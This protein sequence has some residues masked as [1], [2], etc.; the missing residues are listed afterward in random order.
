MAEKKI[1]SVHVGGRR[2]RIRSD[3]NEGWLQGVA[4]YVDESMGRIQSRTETVDSLDVAVLTALNIARELIELRENG[5]G[6]S[7]QALVNPDRIASLIERVESV[8]TSDEA[9]ESRT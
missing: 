4:E 8:L 7:S 9:S 6:Q 1:V 5:P 2:Y 3:A